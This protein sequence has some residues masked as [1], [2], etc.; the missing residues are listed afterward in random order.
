MSRTGLF[1]LILAA[2]QK[3]GSITGEAATIILN[4]LAPTPVL[5]DRLQEDTRRLSARAA[6]LYTVI[7]GRPVP[8][9]AHTSSGKEPLGLLK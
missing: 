9:P 8:A 3:P 2:D 4:L 7:F 1:A 5:H 6:A